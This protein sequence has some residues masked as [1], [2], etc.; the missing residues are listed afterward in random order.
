MELPFEFDLTKPMFEIKTN[1]QHIKIYA[2][3]NVEGVGSD[4]VVVNRIAI[5]LSLLDILKDQLSSSSQAVDL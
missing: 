5:L 4:Y 2:N 1:S 3:G